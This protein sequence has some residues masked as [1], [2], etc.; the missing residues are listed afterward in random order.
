MD[1]ETASDLTNVVC[2]ILRG[3][4]L[5]RPNLDK[6]E[7]A[8]LRTLKYAED[9]T[10][11]PEDKGN[12]TVVLDKD[13]Y[14][15]KLMDLL[16]DPVHEK[17]VKDPTPAIERRILKEVQELE[18]KALIPQGLGMRL[19]PSAS[20]CFISVFTLCSCSNSYCF[21]LIKAAILQPK[22]SNYIYHWC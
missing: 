17:M 5:P 6:D 20:N 10:I 11:L 12:A 15:K 4:K 7:R 3:A 22:L 21:F 1:E 2:G 16:A 14:R 9:I 18:K 8:A 19:K 13:Q